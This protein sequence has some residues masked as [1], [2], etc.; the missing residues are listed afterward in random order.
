VR[1]CIVVVGPSL[2]SGITRLITERVS[3]AKS[4]AMEAC[5]KQWDDMKA[6]GKTEGKTWP[7]FWSECSKD[8]AA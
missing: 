7:S 8:F 5:G 3:A 4:P 2:T 6:A 1:A